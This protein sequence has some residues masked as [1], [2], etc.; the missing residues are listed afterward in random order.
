M[1]VD[2]IARKSGVDPK[3]LGEWD[4]NKLTKGWM[5]PDVSERELRFLATNHYFREVKEKT[6]AHNHLS[7]LLDTG[8]NPCT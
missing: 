6:F 4:S 1:H 7:S 8:K 5:Y 3:K 2:D